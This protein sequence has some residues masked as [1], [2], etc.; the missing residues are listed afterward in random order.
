MKKAKFYQEKKRMNNEGEEKPKD[1]SGTVPE[2]AEKEKGT[3]EEPSDD[4]T[5]VIADLKKSY[6]KKLLDFKSKSDK[7]IKE[8]DEMI[9][10]LAEGEGTA[11][12]MSVADIVNAGR[13][14]KKW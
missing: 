9:K 5:K 3:A 13:V 7:E 1:G 4:M 8:R 10:Q 11:K 2:K 6:E 12:P 14:F